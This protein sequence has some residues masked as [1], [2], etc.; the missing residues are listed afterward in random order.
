MRHH[1][2]ILDMMPLELCEPCK[3][4]GTSALPRIILEAV[5]GLC[6]RF[7]TDSNVKC[8]M[9]VHIENL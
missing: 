8:Q 4:L 7:D 5:P 1:G 6:V 3:S 2:T 9:H